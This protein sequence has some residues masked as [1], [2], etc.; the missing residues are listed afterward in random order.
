[1]RDTPVPY[2]AASTE[3]TTKTLFPGA[4]F[5]ILEAN[6]VPQSELKS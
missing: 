6:M 3:A 5:K 4:S 1:M 2:A